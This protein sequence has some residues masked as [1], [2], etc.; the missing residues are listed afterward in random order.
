MS[1]RSPYSVSPPRTRCARCGLVEV[2]G[3]REDEPVCSRC[4]W[5]MLD[6]VRRERDELRD[7]ARTV[8]EALSSPRA[9]PRTCD[10]PG[11][12]ALA[13]RFDTKSSGYICDKHQVFDGLP[14]SPVDFDYAPAWRR[15]VGLVEGH[16]R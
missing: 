6:E 16:G 15:L 8:V 13:T 3:E 9:H 10:Y 5:E 2:C 11:C 1:Q 14:M 7:A 12:G 4:V